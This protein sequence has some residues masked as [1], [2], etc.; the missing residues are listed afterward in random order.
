MTA[1]D[2]ER[3]RRI[4]RERIMVENINAVLKVFKIMAYP[5]R[6]HRRRHRLRLSLLCG[7]I[8]YD[9]ALKT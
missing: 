6:N 8:N 3:N 2:K 7:I 9:L 4:S 1:A 5:Y